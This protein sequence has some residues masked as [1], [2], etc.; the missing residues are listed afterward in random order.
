ME[1]LGGV[2]KLFSTPLD[3]FSTP[4]TYKRYTLYVYGGVPA[5]TP[6]VNAGTPPAHSFFH[7]FL[8]VLGKKYQILRSL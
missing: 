2:P 8:Y 7:S 3:S 6:P 4:P 5:G 1:Y